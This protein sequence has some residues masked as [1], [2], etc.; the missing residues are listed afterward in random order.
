MKILVVDSHEFT[1][2]GMKAYFKLDHQVMDANTSARAMK[3]PAPDIIISEVHLLQRLDGLSLVSKLREAGRKTPI[4]MHTYEDN[5]TCIARA[6]ALGAQGYLFK[7]AAMCEVAAAIKLVCKGGDAW[8][9]EMLRTVRG[10]LRPSFM[11]EHS[12]TKRELEVL[13]QL[14]LG[15]SNKDI[16]KA[17]GISYET[18]KEHVQHILRKLNVQD[19]TQAAVYAVR[20]HMVA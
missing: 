11:A 2:I 6:V 16:G 7:S 17:L 4:I 14:C 20:K 19:R 9:R 1:V 12:L 10:S 18:V 8:S 13:E 3:M 5:S 15:L